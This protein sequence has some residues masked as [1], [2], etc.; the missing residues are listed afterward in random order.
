MATTNDANVACVTSSG[1]FF[2]AIRA[3]NAAKV[4]TDRR[5]KRFQRSSAKVR[6]RAQRVRRRSRDVE[7]PQAIHRGQCGQQERVW[8]PRY[9]P[10]E[11]ADAATLR[12]GRPAWVSCW[13]ALP[14]VANFCSECGE[15]LAP[16]GG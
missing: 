13:V 16:D 12:K 14:R 15:R 3:H 6:G 2:A 10:P 4:P 1:E 7:R 8:R 9:G 11:A 5:R